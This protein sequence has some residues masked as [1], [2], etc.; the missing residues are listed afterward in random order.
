MSKA[1]LRFASGGPI[2]RIF[3]EGTREA[4]LRGRRSQAELQI[5]GRDAG[6]YSIRYAGEWSA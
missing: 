2:G 6:E 4:E 5:A 3:C 1:I